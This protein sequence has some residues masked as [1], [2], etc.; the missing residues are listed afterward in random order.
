M[1]WLGAE[2]W[3]LLNGSVRQFANSVPFIGAGANELEALT[4]ALLNAPDGQFQQYYGEE[5]AS[6]D[7]MDQEFRALY[8]TLS[9]TAS[10]AGNVLG[11]VALAELAP[12][13]VSLGVGGWAAPVIDNAVTSGAVAGLDS[14]AD[15][16]LDADGT[17]W[18]RIGA[19]FERMPRD[20]IWGATIGPIA[21]R[22]VGSRFGDAAEGVSGKAMGEGIE[23]LISHGGSLIGWLMG[24][25]DPEDSQD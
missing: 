21:D 23:E 6:Q 3:Y 22:I 1:G 14:F 8:P 17:I 7:Q 13:G 9:S 20:M 18:D 25:P 19:G 2:G 10:G 11:A 4:Y 12:V 15:G 24:D 5:L 16:Y